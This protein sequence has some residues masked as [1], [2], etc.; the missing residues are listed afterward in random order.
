MGN[1]VA[2]DE[3]RLRNELAVLDAERRSLFE[4]QNDL[5]KALAQVSQE[6]DDNDNAADRVFEQMQALGIDP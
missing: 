2:H 4:R 6:I 5:R 3:E 1:A